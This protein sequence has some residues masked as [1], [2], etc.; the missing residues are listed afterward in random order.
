METQE[1][2]PQETITP[3]PVVPPA[4]QKFPLWGVAIIVILIGTG[5]L[6]TWR[7]LTLV[8]ETPAVPSPTPTVS[9]S[10][11][12]IRKLSRLASESAFLTLEANVASLSGQLRTFVTD[13]PSLSPPVLELPLG[14]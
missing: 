13:D 8:P 14:F 2:I 3:S 9:S 5:T 12:P 11:T 4:G 6:F 1:N 7:S 10:P